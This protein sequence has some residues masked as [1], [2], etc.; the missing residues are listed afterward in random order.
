MSPKEVKAVEEKANK[1]NLGSIPVSQIMNT[2]V[3]TVK[4]DYSIKRTVEILKLNKLTGA[5][6][7]DQ[8]KQLIGVISEYD[9]LIQAASKPASDLI[10][11]NEKVQAVQPET[12]LKEV[13]VI[14]YK[15]KLKRIPV[16]DKQGVVVGV[17][18]RIDVLTTLINGSED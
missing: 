13:L 2:Q 3:I 9:L 11:Y 10:T 16:I 12:T 8:T 6:V 7:V 17:V 18:E 5:P 15:Q 1:A 14:F 4:A